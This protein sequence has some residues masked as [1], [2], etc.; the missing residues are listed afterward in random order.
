MRPLLRSD[1][2]KPPHIKCHIVGNHVSQLIYS[3]GTVNYSL[4]WIAG[5]HYQIISIVV[6]VLKFRILVA[7]QKGIPNSADPDQTA[8]EEA[9]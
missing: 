1:T 7:F 3:D 2:H 8:S 6:D 9:V 5:L 4:S